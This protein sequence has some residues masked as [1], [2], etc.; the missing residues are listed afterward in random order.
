MNHVVPAALLLMDAAVSVLPTFDKE[1]E[2]ATKNRRSRLNDKIIYLPETGI[3]K[4]IQLSP[5]SKNRV[6]M[7]DSDT[8]SLMAYMP[9]SRSFAYWRKGSD[10]NSNLYLYRLER[11]KS[12]K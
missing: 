8:P 1:R 2:T 11:K 4:T 6:G 12:K 5:R 3:K 9:S 10:G 7:M